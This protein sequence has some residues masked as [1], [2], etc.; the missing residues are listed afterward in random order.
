MTAEPDRRRAATVAAVRAVGF[1]V[2][3]LMLAGRDPDDLIVGMVSAVLA[4][5]ASM[6]LLPPSGR[7]L[8]PMA[9]LAF[10]GH[11]LVQS[12]RAGWDVALCAF[13]PSLPLRPGF[14]TF[15]SRIAS[16]ETRAAFLGVSSLMP[17]TLPCG[18][19]ESGATIVHALDVSRPIAADLAADEARFGRLVSDG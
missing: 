6:L 18:V 16:P 11:F 13:K 5:W 4:T 3:W 8:H 10:T 7:R 14:V 12:L 9:I 2:F 19:D 17:G 15:R 1:F